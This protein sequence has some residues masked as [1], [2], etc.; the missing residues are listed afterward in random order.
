MNDNMPRSNLQISSDYRFQWEEAQ[1]CFVLLYPEGM[2]QLSSTAG[3]ILQRCQQKI[4]ISDLLKSLQK[5]FPDA[6]ELVAD[7]LEF[8]HDAEQQ[9]WLNRESQEV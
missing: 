3:E 7:V 2:I 9:G 6:D 8:I 4:V 1:Q 5:S